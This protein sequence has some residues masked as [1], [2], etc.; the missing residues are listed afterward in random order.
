MKLINRITY[1]YLLITYALVL[2][3]CKAKKIEKV[4]TITQEVFRDT[5]SVK[6]ITRTE[7][8][9]YYDTITKKLYVYPKFKIEN[10]Q[11]KKAVTQEKKEE[12]KETKREVEQK[13]V[14]N[15]KLV[16]WLIIALAIS[17]ALNIWKFIK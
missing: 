5:G 14:N 7:Y 2:I 13:A 16:F 12:K 3:G 15:L 6:T 11:E 10:K 8:V 17:L 9:H 4:E 1:L